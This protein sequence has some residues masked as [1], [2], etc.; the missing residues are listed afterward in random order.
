M[1]A[2]IFIIIVIIIIVTIWLVPEPSQQILRMSSVS[3]DVTQEVRPAR[4]WLRPVLWWFAMFRVSDIGGVDLNSSESTHT[5][6]PHS[7]FCFFSESHLMWHIAMHL[8]PVLVE[9]PVA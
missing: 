5:L 8:Q 7:L 4:L 3:P 2:L 9:E 1:R 6:R